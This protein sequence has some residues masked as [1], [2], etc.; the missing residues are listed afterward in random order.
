MAFPKKSKKCRESNWLY[1]VKVGWLSYLI[2][3][4]IAM[5]NVDV[6]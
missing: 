6:E 4:Y 1:M 5:G 2:I 3:C